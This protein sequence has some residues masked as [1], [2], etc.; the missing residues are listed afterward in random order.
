VAA[1]GVVSS[2]RPRDGDITYTPYRVEL[3]ALA[4]RRRST[5]PYATLSRLLCPSASVFIII[6]ILGGNIF[7]GIYFIVNWPVPLPRLGGDYYR[8]NTFYAVRWPDT[9][10]RPVF[11]MDPLPE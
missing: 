1:S 11:D 10:G 4:Y 7:Y 2:S 5:K 8:E 9:R 3:I 6:F